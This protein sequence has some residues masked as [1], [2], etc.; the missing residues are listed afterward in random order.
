MYA[1]VFRVRAQHIPDNRTE[2]NGSVCRLRLSAYA[3]KY[4]K[5]IYKILFIYFGFVDH[6]ARQ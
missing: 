3:Q 6:Y 2:T 1:H 5:N 4:I